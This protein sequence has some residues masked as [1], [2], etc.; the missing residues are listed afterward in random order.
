LDIVK[1][2]VKETGDDMLKRI[3][4]ANKLKEEERERARKER[5]LQKKLNP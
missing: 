4:M 5:K 3:R 1:I 2:T